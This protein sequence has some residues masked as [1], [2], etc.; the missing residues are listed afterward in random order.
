MLRYDVS[1]R[2]PFCQEYQELSEIV[3]IS[4][5]SQENV[6]QIDESYGLFQKKNKWVVGEGGIGDMGFPSVWKK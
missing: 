5:K 2:L 1:T 6:R 4:P 3:V